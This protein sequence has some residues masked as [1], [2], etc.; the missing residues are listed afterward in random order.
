ML[1]ATIATIT[2]ATI[3]IATIT[4]ATITIATVATIIVTTFTITIFDVGDALLRAV[5]GTL[6]D[7]SG[8]SYNY[9][10]D[11]AV[12]N[13]GGMFGCASRDIFERIHPIVSETCHP[14]PIELNDPSAGGGS[15]L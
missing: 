3:T 15:K 9:K 10:K 1:L 13:L 8:R 11:T 7:I 14:W 12:D 5:G 2:I 6:T 4:I